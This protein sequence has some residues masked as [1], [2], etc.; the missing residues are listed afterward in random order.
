MHHSV[1][2]KVEY[3][4]SKTPRIVIKVGSS[5]LTDQNKLVPRWA[6]LQR[7]MED[8]GVLTARGYEVILCSSG[9]VSL[10]MKMIGLTPATAGLRDKQAAA[11]CGMPLLLN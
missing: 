4:V 5:L 3:I 6:F 8:I 11:A 1:N 9:A 2:K 7:L 10:G